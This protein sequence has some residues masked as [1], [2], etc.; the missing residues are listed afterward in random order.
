MSKIRDYGTREMVDVDG[1]EYVVVTD[2]VAETTHKINLSDYIV[3]VG[4]GV[5]VLNDLTDVTITSPQ[6][7]QVMMYIDGVNGWGNPVIAG[8]SGNFQSSD[9]YSVTVVNGIITVLS[10][11]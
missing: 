11:S 4:G 3:E 2:L 7:G 5:S 8:A 1:N 10:G 6:D 9:G